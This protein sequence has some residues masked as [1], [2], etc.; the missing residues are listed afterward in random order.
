MAFRLKERDVLIVAKG[1][2]RVD[3][4][5]YKEYFKEKAKMLK[6]DEVLEVTGHPV[7]GVCP[8]GLK[9]RL[10]I[11]LDQSLREFDYVFPAGGSPNSAVRISPS[12]LEPV[13]GENGWMCAPERQRLLIPEKTI[14]AWRWS[15]L[16]KT[17]FEK[18]QSRFDYNRC[19]HGNIVKEFL[20]IPIGQA[21][22]TPGP[23]R[24]Q[25]GTTAAVDS[26]AAA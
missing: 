18:I 24:T 4:R 12:Q 6:S 3:N 17:S 21:D 5:K 16:S 7:G 25:A 8:F 13:T 15:F 11:Y 10:A 22:A 19:A 26:D 2:A 9:Q 14:V 23:V 20:N 1:D